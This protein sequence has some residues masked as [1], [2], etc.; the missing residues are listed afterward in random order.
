MTHIYTTM[1]KIAN[2]KLLY[3]TEAQS[4]TLWWPRG[5][6]ERRV[7]G[8]HNS[9][10]LWLI[11]IVVWQKLTQHYKAMTLFLEYKTLWKENINRENKEVT[12]QGTVWAGVVSIPKFTCWSS[13]VIVFE[14]GAL[15]SRY[16]RKDGA[17][18]KKRKT[19]LSFPLRHMRS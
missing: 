4:G 2:G 16:A 12:K 19:E 17:L 3:D 11:Q 8:S 15:G 18:E 5:W 10:G 6:E 13:H 9:Y 7:G 14:D 1:C